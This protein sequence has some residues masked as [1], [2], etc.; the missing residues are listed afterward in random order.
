M[1]RDLAE[2]LRQLNEK[3]SKLL[4]RLVTFGDPL[5]QQVGQNF[6]Y[7]LRQRPSQA[8]VCS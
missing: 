8:A 7:P 1:T 3:I 4:L 5:L 2:Q 6:D